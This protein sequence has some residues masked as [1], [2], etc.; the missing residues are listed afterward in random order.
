MTTGDIVEENRSVRDKAVTVPFSDDETNKEAAEL[1][2]DKPDASP[3]ERKTRSQKRAERVK[4][5]MDEG[6]QHKQRADKLE[7]ELGSLRGEVE[8]LKGFA[9][10]V[11]QRPVPQADGG[12]DP[13]ERDLD[14]VYKKRDDAYTAM[15]A[16]MKAGALSDERT[17]HY[18]NIGREV[19]AE[20]SR[21]HIAKAL[22]ANEVQRRAESSQAVWRNKYPEVYD[23]PKAYQYAEG[24]YRMRRADEPDS[25]ALVDD[26]MQQ[27]M[28]RYKLGGRSQPTASDRA[29]MS[30]V[31]TGGSSS[32]GSR[33]PAGIRM[34]KNLNKMATAAYP[35]LPEEEAV[36]RW[37]NRTGKRLRERKV[38]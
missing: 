24:L 20:I 26:C 11:A 27:A 13:Y 36:K 6:A 4:R 29:K 12:K 1:D 18:H 31:P 10:A 25:N 2:E 15:Q 17:R 34:T 32:G 28:T 14:A 9:T 16:E 19:E 30:G 3:E 21:I 8:R 22:A 37:V 35:D 23:N 5:I 33:E 7:S 38:L